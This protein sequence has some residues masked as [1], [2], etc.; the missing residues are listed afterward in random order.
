MIFIASNFK[1][2]RFKVGAYTS[3]ISMEIIFDGM[4]NE[5]M[6]VFCVENDVK[7]VFDK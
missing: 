2:S 4:V 7:V 5:G 1:R 6:P 3:E